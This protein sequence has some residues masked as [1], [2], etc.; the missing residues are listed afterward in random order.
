M[1]ADTKVAV[2][3]TPP[4]ISTVVASNVAF[5][6][7]NVRNPVSGELDDK[8]LHKCY[9]RTK[10]RCKRDNYKIARVLGHGV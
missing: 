7:D 5:A 3:A 1:S 8:W 6:S 2:A 4:Y 10:Y 9:E